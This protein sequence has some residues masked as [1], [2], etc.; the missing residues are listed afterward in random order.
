M[1]TL[2]ALEWFRWF[3]RLRELPNG[4]PA[5]ALENKFHQNILV[6]KFELSNLLNASQARFTAS[7]QQV[8]ACRKYS[9]AID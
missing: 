3:K 2:Q 5:F 1:T 7:M 9:E 6:V 4:N 8:G